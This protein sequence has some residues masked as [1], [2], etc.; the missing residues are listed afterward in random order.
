MATFSVSDP[1]NNTLTVGVSGDDSTG[2]IVE[3]NSIL[4]YVGGVNF[5]NPTDSDGNNVYNIQVFADDGFNRTTQDVE[6]TVSD[7]PESPEFVG[8]DSDVFVEENVRIVTS[9]SVVDPEGSGVS[10]AINGGADESLFR[11][12]NVDEANGSLAFIAFDGA[13]YEEP[14]DANSDGI[15]EVQLRAVE[16]TAEALE[17][18]I[19]LLITVTDIKDTYT[20]NGTLYSNRYTAIDGD[21]QNTLKYTYTENNSASSAQTITQSN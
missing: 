1:E 9:I 10:W 5:E 8:L 20:I 3:D 12:F 16:D 15:Y 11:T 19:D 2:F 4:K 13:D 18:I 17:T 14:T 7:V 21:V 6:I